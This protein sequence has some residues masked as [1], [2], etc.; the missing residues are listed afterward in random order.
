MNIKEYKK[1]IIMIVLTFATQLL[2]MI[3]TSFM[4]ANFGTSIGMDA[5]NF[6][7]SITTFIFSFTSAGATTIL[8]PSMLDQNKKKAVSKFITFLYMILAIVSLLVI[9]NRKYIINGLSDFGDEFIYIASKLLVIMLISQFILSFQSISNAFFQCQEKFNIPKI[10][11]FISTILLVMVILVEKGR[12][13]IYGYSILI[14][15]STVINIAIQSIFLA[16]YKF[17]F[18]VDFDFKNSDFKNMIK[19]FIP[20]VCST[21]VYQVSIMINTMLSA[22]LG[23]GSVSLMTYSNT[24]IS[25]TN[26]LLMANIMTYFYPKIVIICKKKS[27]D[28]IEMILMS[29]IGITGIVIVGFILV[30]RDGVELLYQRGAFTEDHSDSVYSLALVAIL[31]L[32]AIGIRDVYYR[33][34]YSYGYTEIPF[35]NSIII[36]VISIILSLLLSKVYGVIGI[37]LGTV[38]G[39]YISMVLISKKFLT[40]FKVDLSKKH[41][42]NIAKIGIVSTITFSIVYILK[43]LLINNNIIFRFTLV[44]ISTIIVYFILVLLI[45]Y[46]KK[47]T[48]IYRKIRK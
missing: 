8:I 35:K 28:N 11:T 18:K 36:S 14:L 15:F 43:C 25:M 40:T 3:K 45:I 4:A 12:I 7:N 38:I 42:I 34:F 27:Y 23:Q 33:C 9:I 47:L 10:I 2:I 29:I 32:P 24:I 6:I 13:T 44:A 39:S 46:P 21:G 22:N 30:G 41:K 17:S 37:V 31:A 16:K 5:F 48:N 26:T 19:T 20:I 1:I